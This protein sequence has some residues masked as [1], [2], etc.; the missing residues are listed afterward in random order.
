MMGL[1]TSSIKNQ[2]IADNGSVLN[3]KAIP[4]RTK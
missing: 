2:I 1:W 4:E 3:I